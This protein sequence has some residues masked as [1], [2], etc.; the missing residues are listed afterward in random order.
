MLNTFLRRAEAGE[1][2]YITDVRE[3]FQA[4]GTRP[5][6]IHVTLYDHTVRV[7]SLVL[8]Q[9]SGRAEAEF[10]AEYV[11]AT[12]YNILSALGAVRVDI[13]LNAS[14]ISLWE[15]AEGLNEV[16]QTGR[17]KALRSGYGKCLNVN[18]R[19]LSALF[20]GQ[21]KFALRI[22]DLKNEPVAARTAARAPDR[23]V[24]DQLPGRTAGKLILGMDVGGTDVKLAV[25][26]DGRL[27]LCKEFDWDPSAFTRAEELTGPLLLLTRLLRAA[28]SL[29]RAGREGELDRTLLTRNASLSELERGAEAMELAA[30]KDLRNFD[31]I[32][33]CFPDV[34]IQNRVVGGE[35]P[36]TQG[37]RNNPELDY[38]EQFGRITPLAGALATYVVPGGP[39]RCVND[40]PMAAFTAAVEQGAGGAD[41]S[42]GFFAHTLGTDLGTG[43]VRPDGSIPDIPL[44]VYSFIIDLGSYPQ[45]KFDPED[46]RSVYSSNSR[47][48]GALQ[49]Y[50]GQSGVFRLAARN[51]PQKD[52]ALFQEAMDRGLLR[53]EGERLVVPVRPEDMRKE[54]LEF[55]ME[56]AAQPGREVC[57][58][59]FREIGEYQAVVWRETNFILRP[60][61][62][63]RSLFGRLVKLPAC[64]RLIQEGASRREPGLR[65]LAADSGLANTLLMKQLA[66]HPHYTVAQF[67]Q[68]VG[69][70]Y[71][72]CL[73][74]TR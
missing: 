20:Q 15:L 31:A 42:K 25:S 56:K 64:F 38:E 72:A 12:L 32:G 19:V 70:V 66:A 33:L 36:K 67:A 2:V 29:S 17:E 49:K 54:A 30:G 50:G 35:T 22:F 10:T 1:P 58:D 59:I 68:A 37:M 39:V 45:R 62:Q 46:I 26:I 13:Y 47:L 27:A 34:V 4:E 6:H 28:G 16:F 73:D 3:A 61:A 63:E 11:Y 57:Q 9:V 21:E 40:G 18:E 23:P 5:F 8:P 55:F 71:Y 60:E 24:F 52:P 69:A 14:D 48:P 7:F 65:L 51:L 43:W 41:L 74:E 44:E 53:W